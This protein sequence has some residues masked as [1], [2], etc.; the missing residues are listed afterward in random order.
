MRLLSEGSLMIREVSRE[1]AGEYT[2]HVE[3]AYG[4]DTV[5]HKL[6]IQGN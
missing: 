3:N 5:T 4:Q 1:D 6:L 2:C